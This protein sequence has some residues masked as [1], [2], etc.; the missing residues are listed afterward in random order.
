MYAPENTV[1]GANAFDP[2]QT[3]E[4][5]MEQFEIEFSWSW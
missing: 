2:T 1:R 5:T 4:L 3:I